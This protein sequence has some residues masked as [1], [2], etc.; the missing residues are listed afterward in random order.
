M[1]DVGSIRP[2][3]DRHNVANT[4]IQPLPTGTRKTLVR[5]YFGRYLPSGHLIY[6]HDGTVFAAAFNLERLEM[7]GP[8]VPI[9]TDVVASTILGAAQ[10]T[11]SDRGTAAYVPVGK[12]GAGEAISSVARPA[13]QQ[14][15]Q[16]GSRNRRPL[17]RPSPRWRTNRRTLTLKPKSDETQERIIFL[18]NFFDEVRRRAVASK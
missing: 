12:T 3:V 15:T 16:R 11:V 4:A 5:G 6:L 8:A 14:A 18:F 9:L 17:V 13:R 2:C 10:F 7:I 1:R